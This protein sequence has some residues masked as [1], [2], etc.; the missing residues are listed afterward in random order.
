M[1]ANLKE[2][3]VTLNNSP[4][5]WW[6][7]FTFDN[8]VRRLLHNPE[9]ILGGLIQPGQTVADIGCGMGYFSGD[10]SRKSPGRD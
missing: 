3:I 4:C 9:Q 5:P 8:P 6:L 7:C 1:H 10:R 2:K